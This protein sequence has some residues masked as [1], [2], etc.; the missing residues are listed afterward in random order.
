MT[1]LFGSKEHVL[2]RWL[3]TALD[4]ALER[5]RYIRF[6][7]SSVH[8]HEA[9]LMN[10][11]V[12][13][14]CAACNNGWMND[15]EE[16]VRHFLP[17][18]IRGAEVE[19]DHVRQV[20]L[21]T[22]SLK[23]MLMYQ[24]THGREAQ[25][26]IPAMDYAAFF[27]ERR[28]SRFMLGRVAFMNYPPDDSVPLADA[29]CQGYGSPQGAAW[30]STLKIGCLVTQIVRVADFDEQWRVEPFESF[31]SLRHVWP[32]ADLI[33]WPLPLAIPHEHMS[34]LALPNSL[35]VRLMPR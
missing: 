17:A 4:P 2:P 26:V 35:D 16:S 14:V 19:L 33:D 10:E 15:L 23:T 21:A 8:T 12:R 3:R 31:P 1:S 5:A 7:N 18:L 13:V 28:P 32:T 27:E 9:P 29:L 25:S 20:H 30:I 6:T 22:W 34:D 24:H 11:Q